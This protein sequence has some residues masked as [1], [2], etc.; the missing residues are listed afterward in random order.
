MPDTTPAAL[1]AGDA[2]YA[3]QHAADWARADLDPA[4]G[5]AYA[6]WYMTEFGQRAETLADLPAHPRVWL[7]FLDHERAQQA[8]T[9]AETP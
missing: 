8:E 3:R 9:E 7:R 4:R 6:D 5:N 2:E 1:P